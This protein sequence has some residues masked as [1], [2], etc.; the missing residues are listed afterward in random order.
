MRVLLIECH[1]ILRQG[2]KALLISEGID[3]VGDVRSGE[4]ALA[5]VEELQPSVVVTDI[6]LPGMSGIEATAL[7]RQKCPS[8]HVLAFSLD[9]DGAFVG[10]MFQAGATGYVTKDS[11]FEELL[12]AIRVVSQGRTF[13]SQSITD[14]VLRSYASRVETTTHA[15]LSAREAQVLAALAEGK[16]SRAIAQ[17][18]SLSVTTVDTH[19]RRIS[20]K[21]GVKSVAGLT[22]FALRNGICQLGE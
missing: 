17:A 13:A 18:L 11:T 19:R 2:M 10:A 15:A 3:V 14:L 1:E 9:R 20:Q 6:G 7:I 16:S 8:T 21:L 4:E 5:C 12:T 22:K